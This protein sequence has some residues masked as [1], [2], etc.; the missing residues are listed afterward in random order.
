MA[1]PNPPNL[2][3]ITADQY[4]GDCLGLAGHPAVMTPNLD[5]WFNDGAYFPRAYSECPSCIAAR[6]R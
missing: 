1:K 3:L 6:R 5:S 2:L 4:R